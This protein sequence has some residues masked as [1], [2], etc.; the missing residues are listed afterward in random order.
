MQ[1]LL[2]HNDYEES[3]VS[4]PRPDLI[5]DALHGNRHVLVKLHGDWQD[6]VGCT[7]AR[8][9]YCASYGDAQTALKRR[10]LHSAQ[11]TAAAAAAPHLL[12]QPFAAQFDTAPL[13]LQPHFGRIAN[14]LQAGRLNFF[15]G[16]AVHGLTKLVAQHFSLDVARTF[17]CKSL[18]DQR[19]AFIRHIEDRHGRK[20]LG[21]EIDKLLGRSELRPPEAH[22]LIAASPRASPTGCLRWS[23][24]A[25]AIA[26]CCFW[27]MAWPS[28]VWKPWFASCITNSA[29]SCPW[30]WC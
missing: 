19:A 16:F 14:L 21:A 27:A 5:V 26:R 2:D 28:P 30:S 24:N 25:C 15:L 10:L 12:R 20:T 23:A 3:V 6:R 11:C 29:A 1:A 17:E 7:F 8:S 4:G 9:D 13:E 22:E 18:A